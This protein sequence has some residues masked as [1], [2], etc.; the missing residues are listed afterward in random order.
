MVVPQRWRKHPAIWSEAR[1]EILR[2]GRSVI[3]VSQSSGVDVEMDVVRRRVA[4]FLEQTQRLD[5]G[6]RNHGMLPR[7]A[8]RKE[9]GELWP[10]SGARGGGERWPVT[11]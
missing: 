3:L 9:N 5:K 10:S 6:R 4:A 11:P 8:S 1:D 2:C 7:P